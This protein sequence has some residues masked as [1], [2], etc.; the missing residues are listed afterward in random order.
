MRAVLPRT[1][2][3][4][5]LSRTASA[6]SPRVSLSRH[7]STGC[8]FS[9]A[10]GSVGS[11]RI[12]LHFDINHRKDSPAPARGIRRAFSESDIIR[13]EIGF[14]GLSGAGS[15]SFPARIPE[16]EHLSEI[17]D[18]GE[19][20]VLNGPRIW[21]EIGI[22]LE[23]LG[24]F[25]GGGKPGGGGGGYDGIG[26]GDDRS[27]IG[28]YYLEMLKSNPGDSLLLRNYGKFLHEVLRLSRT[29]FSS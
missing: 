13:S 23:E 25:G 1:G 19:R 5:V 12:S 9:G 16:D 14:S 2:S 18:E 15:L 27:K 22:P 6:G 21:P 8:F 26:S 11:P 28:A 3:V 7:D 29:T 17:D 4:P 24:F 10:K 20:L